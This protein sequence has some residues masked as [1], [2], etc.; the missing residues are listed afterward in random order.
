VRFDNL[1]RAARYPES[2]QA[3]RTQ[4]RPAHPRSE[5]DAVGW[6][7]WFSAVA[8]DHT[9]DSGLA[10]GDSLQTSASAN[11]MPAL[12]AD[13]ARRRFERLCTSRRRQHRGL[14][15]TDEY[16]GRDHHRFTA[17]RLSGRVKASVEG[18]HQPLTR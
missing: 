8:D 10:V 17:P 2:M 18:S 11:T 3:S 13:E 5:R 6:P 12:H 1:N 4:P 14:G 15:E 7:S 16:A 9:G